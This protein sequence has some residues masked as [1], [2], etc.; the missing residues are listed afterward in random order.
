MTPGVEIDPEQI[1]SAQP[2]EDRQDLAGRYPVVPSHRNQVDLE[3]ARLSDAR[4]PPVCA[5]E[6]RGRNRD[7]AKRSHAGVPQAVAPVC[8]L[9]V[10]AAE[11]LV[12]ANGDG[13]HAAS[14]FAWPARW[15]IAA[16]NRSGT[17]LIEPA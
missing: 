7:R 3:N 12:G 10:R 8:R 6:S 14:P 13:T 16:I 2:V 5:I 11:A 17:V 1:L 15:V 4:H 9:D